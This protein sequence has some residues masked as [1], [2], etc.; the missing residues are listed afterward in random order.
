[1]PKILT[2]GYDDSDRKREP[3]RR[4]DD[5]TADRVAA[6]FQPVEVGVRRRSLAPTVEA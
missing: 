1:V 5:P 3:R 4:I 6:S 2:R